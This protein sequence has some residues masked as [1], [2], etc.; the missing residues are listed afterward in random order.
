MKGE[1][2]TTQTEDRVRLHGLYCVPIA[3]PKTR[4]DAVVLT[5]GLASN[6]YSSRFLNYVAHGFLE[7]GIHV[8]I[9]NTRGHD[10]V[11]RTVR[12]GRSA[13]LGAAF[14][15]VGECRFDLAGWNQFLI[16][17]GHQKNILAGHSLGAIK[18]LYAMAY[19]PQP[20]IE[21]IVGLS[22]IRLNYDSLMNSSGSEA[23]T[24]MLQ[25]AEQLVEAG[26]GD[27]LMKV[28]FPY[29]TLMAAEAYLNKYGNASEYDWMQFIDRVD[30]PTQLI[31]GDLELAESPALEGLQDQ[32]V[33]LQKQNPRLTVD[34][35]P[36]ADHFYSARFAEAVETMRTWL[37]AH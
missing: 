19:Q 35:V 29:P 11:N 25:Q 18:S 33:S 15:N 8:V 12:M 2:V 27:S 23:F 37:V 10:D 7:L 24:R 20:N 21:A 17:R 31:Y 30:V 28:D 34:V 32:F 16:S 6:F 5:H 22:A 1:I 13:Y 36:G 3:E 4:F 14:E 26:E 9:G